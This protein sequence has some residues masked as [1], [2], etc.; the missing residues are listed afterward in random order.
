MAGVMSLVEGSREG[1]S[2]QTSG[3]AA[4]AA[5]G[6]TALSSPARR[7]RAGLVAIATVESWNGFIGSCCRSLFGSAETHSLEGTP[8]GLERA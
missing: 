5:M 4:R 8:D 7:S 3:M 6:R 2:T 1:A